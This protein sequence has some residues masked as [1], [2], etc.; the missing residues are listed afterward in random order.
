MPRLPTPSDFPTLSITPPPSAPSPVTAPKPP[1][2]VLLLLHG[3]GDTLTPFTTLSQQLGLPET[4]CIALQAP[5]PLPFDLGGFHWGDD[6]VFDQSTGEMEFDTGFTNSTKVLGEVIHVLIEK[7]GFQSREVLLFGFGQGGMAALAATAEVKGEL[8]GVVDIGGPVP[9][10]IPIPSTSTPSSNPS[11]STS[12]TP[13]PSKN[14]TPILLLG[15]SSRTLLTPS[16][17]QKT[18][19]IFPFTEYKKWP[20]AGDGMP[21]TREEMFPIMEFFSRR[22]RSRRGVPEGSVEIG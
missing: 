10:S 4:C 9:S 6:I 17:I 19:V 2:N 1:I 20:R 14:R 8:G 13:P 12:S 3:L 7:C 16:A 21:R 22:L 18:K 5:T 11:P 15:G